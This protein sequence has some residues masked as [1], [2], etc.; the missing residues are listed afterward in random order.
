MVSIPLFS[1]RITARADRLAFR[2]DPPVSIPLFSGRITAVSPHMVSAMWMASQS[3]C[4][5]G[6]LLRERDDDGYMRAVVSI[7]L[8][9]GRITAG[10]QGSNRSRDSVSIPLFSGRITAASP[11]GSHQR[12]E[13]LNPFVFRAYYCV[14]EKTKGEVMSRS[15]SLCFQ[16]VLLRS[17][18]N[19]TPTEA[20]V[21]IPLFSGRITAKCSI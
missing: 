18:S 8:F 15:Q 2:S 4:F 1:G 11:L 21:S 16:G 17:A 7:P 5:Q 10:G 6:V 13:R 9:S 19:Q 14:K 3:L 12:G 20:G